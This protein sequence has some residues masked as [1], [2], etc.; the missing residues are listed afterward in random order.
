MLIDL[1]I[2]T[3]AQKWKRH[4]KEIEPEWEQITIQKEL[5]LTTRIHLKKI[6]MH[7]CGLKKKKEEALHACVSGKN[8]DTRIL[9]F[10]ILN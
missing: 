4:L 8:T 7:F 5:Y 10:R 9:H 1:N 2:E 6:Q 3:R